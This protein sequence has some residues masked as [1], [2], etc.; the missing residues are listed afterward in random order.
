[1]ADHLFDNVQRHLNKMVLDDPRLMSGAFWAELRVFLAVAK[2]KSFNRAA[3]VLNMSQPTVSRHVHRLQDVLGAQLLLSTPGG[4]KLTQRGQDLARTLA[5]MDRK[6]G[7]ISSDFRLEKSDAEGLVRINVTEA[8]AGLFIVPRMEAFTSSYPGIRLHIANPTNMSA[9]RE[10]HADI[11]LNFSPETS[12]EVRSWQ[13]GTVHLLPVASTSYL[14]RYGLPDTATLRHHVL[15][16]TAYYMGDAPVW[17]RWRA[18]VA[19]A[20]TVHGCDNSFAYALMVRSGV[21][22]GLLANYALADGAAVAL[23]LGVHVRLPLHLHVM[24]DRLEARPVRIVYDW[25]ATLFGPDEAWFQADHV[26][27][28]HQRAALAPVVAEIASHPSA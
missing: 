13:G 9:L 5:E 4:V 26:P 19:E 8:L 11:L 10:N 1:M 7:A 21:G 15:L 27:S 28:E 6:I 23:D 20:G 18:L 14:D 22:I 3:Q 17:S 16:D 2:L 12:P 25:L 24:R